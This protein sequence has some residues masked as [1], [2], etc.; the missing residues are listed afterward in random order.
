MSI[1]VKHAHQ[2][3]FIVRQHTA[4]LV[5]EQEEVR[6]AAYILATMPKGPVFRMGAWC[7]VK[8]TGLKSYKT[9][10]L[11]EFVPDLEEVEHGKRLHSWWVTS[12]E[13]EYH[14]PWLEYQRNLV[15]LPASL[16]NCTV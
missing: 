10:T 4:N 7:K 12:I 3:P 1:L 6:L 13:N 14:E 8:A 11:V 5:A 16:G 15:L 2:D 9:V